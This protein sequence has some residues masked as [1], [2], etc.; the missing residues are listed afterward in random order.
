[1]AGKVHARI[2]V[3][4]LCRVEVHVHRLG[5]LSHSGDN[6]LNG[7]KQKVDRISIRGG[8]W[9]WWSDGRREVTRRGH[10][11]VGREMWSCLFCG[12]VRKLGAGNGCHSNCKFRSDRILTI[13]G[14]FRHKK[15]LPCVILLH[16]DPASV[17]A[18]RLLDH[19]TRPL[20]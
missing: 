11:I 12:V 3:L 4:I 17:W 16:E 19:V 20:P 14:K 5:A 2:D 8:K 10:Y 18:L 1:M 6:G 9:S 7:K 15:S 13:I